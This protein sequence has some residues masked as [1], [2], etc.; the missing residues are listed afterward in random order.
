MI[1]PYYSDEWVT[2]YHGELNQSPA[3]CSI[4]VKACQFLIDIR[5]SIN[6]FLRECLSR[7]NTLNLPPIYYYNAYWE[8][9]KV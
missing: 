7:F 8:G 6:D 2:I 3:Y 9:S 4:I 5:S 1:K